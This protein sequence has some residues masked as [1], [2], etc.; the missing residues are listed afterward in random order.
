ML[1]SFYPCLRPLKPPRELKRCHYCNKGFGL[2]R[3]NYP[4]CNPN[5][6]EAFS[7]AIYR[8]Q[9]WVS[10]VVVVE[11]RFAGTWTRKD[12]HIEVEPFGKL[13]RKAVDAE[14]ERIQRS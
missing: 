13:P 4:F 7:E 12:G 14:I 6:K 1:D 10:A 9:G 8:P 11:G 3:P 2:T 5:C